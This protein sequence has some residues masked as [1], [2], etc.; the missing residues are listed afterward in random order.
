METSATKGRKIKYNLVGILSYKK[1]MYTAVVKKRMDG[2]L[3]KQ[4]LTFCQSEM[5][6]I[7]E[8][9]ALKKYPA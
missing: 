1:N 2:H 9:E 6:Q 8:K 4:W 7:T 5:K 3:K